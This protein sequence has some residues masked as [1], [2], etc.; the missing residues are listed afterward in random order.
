MRKFLKPMITR[1]FHCILFSFLAL[2][3]MVSCDSTASQIEYADV[4]GI[5]K[6]EG[7]MAIT[8]GADEGLDWPDLGHLNYG[9]TLLHTVTLSDT[10][11]VVANIDTDNHMSFVVFLPPTNIMG[12][13]IEIL[14]IN[15]E[16]VPTTIKGNHVVSWTMREIPTSTIG[17]P[18]ETL[19][20]PVDNIEI[21]YIENDDSETIT[22]KGYLAASMVNFHI[23]LDLMIEEAPGLLSPG[24]T[25]WMEYQGM[26]NVM[27]NPSDLDI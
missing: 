22:A 11:P 21:L 24:C 5:Y 8:V 15:I 14:Y 12:R 20:V 17:L 1:T 6:G 19:Y 13:E 2:V 27:Y 7:Q 26:A 9:D 4:V 18:I 23:H 10:I 16:Q 25:M 3:A